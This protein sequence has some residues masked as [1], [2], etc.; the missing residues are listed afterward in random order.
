MQDVSNTLTYFKSHLVAK[1]RTAFDGFREKI[2]HFP[3]FVL[4]RSDIPDLRV[5]LENHEALE[6]T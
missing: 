6:Q 3:C 1:L 5:L 2:T 4:S